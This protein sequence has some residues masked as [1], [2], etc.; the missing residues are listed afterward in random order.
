MVIFEKNR[1]R[2]SLQ[3]L[4]VVFIIL[5]NDKFYRKRLLEL[6][7]GKNGETPHTQNN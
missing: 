4:G 6:F 1:K 5:F 3:F 2:V 7:S